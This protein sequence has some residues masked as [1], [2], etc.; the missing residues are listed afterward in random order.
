[1]IHIFDNVIPDPEA[2]R[3]QAL[4]AKF[5]TIEIGPAAFHGI[6]Y[7]TDSLMAD[8]IIQLFPQ[9]T[10]TSSLVRKSPYKQEEPNF[11]HTDRDMGDW[12]A[13]LYLNP[14]PRMSDGT[15][16]W[17]YLPTGEIESSSQ[18]PEEF[19]DEWIAWR[20]PTLWFEWEWVPA[21]FN[22]MIMFPAGLFH[23]RAIFD[24][25]GQDD[26]ARLVQIVFGTG[27]LPKVVNE[28]LICQ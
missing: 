19:M 6:T 3:Q 9:L 23:S 11:I 5:Q 15:S 2:Y 21:R 28:A 26:E 13:I 25:Y 4:Q 12:T 16:F 22:R 27:E 20:D 14:I 10:P 17:K 18:T 24:N 1:M 8:R 7:Y